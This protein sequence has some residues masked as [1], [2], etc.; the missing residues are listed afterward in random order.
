MIN[1]LRIGL[2]TCAFTLTLS[3]FSQQAKQKL[4][5]D[6]KIDALISKMTLEEKV[7]QLNINVGETIITGPTMYTSTSERFDDLIRDGKITGLFNV[8]G[9]AYTARLQKIAIEKSRLGIPLLFGADIIHGF[10]TVTPIPLGEAASWD[11]NAIEQSA[12]MAAKESTSAG[13]NFNFA[14]MVDISREPRWGRISEGSGEDSYLGSRIATARVKGFQG[15]NLAD[16]TTFAACVKHFIGYGAA[17]AGRDYNTVDFSKRALYETY[18]PPF[19]AAI[20]AGAATVMPSFNELDGQPLTGNKHLLT[21]LLRN[22][23]KFNGMIVSDYGAIGEMINH[24]TAANGKEAA[25]LSLEAGTDMDM[26]SYLYLNEVPNLVRAGKLDVKYVDAAVR[27]VLKLKFDLG[28]F[29]NPYLYSDVNREKKE[30]RSAENLAVARDMAKRSIVLLKNEGKLLP[31]KKNYKKIAVIGPLADNKED[32]N[33]SW[34]FFG[35]TQ[36]PVSIVEGIKSKVE[37]GTEVLYHTGCNLYDNNTD[38]FAE[39]V[40]TANNAD[41]V[42]MVVGESAVMN[43]EGASRSDINLPGVQQQLVEIIAK[44]GKPV[45]V[46]LINGRPLTLE[47]IDQHIPSIVESWTLGSEAGHAVADVLFGD[48]NPSGKLPVTFPRSVGQ[49]PIYYNHKN[50]GRPYGGNYSE[51]ASQRVYSSKYRDIKNTPLYPFGYGLSYTSF[52]YS[53]MNLSVPKISANEKIDVTITV[54]NTGAYDG[55]EVVQL[56]IR[57]LVGSVTRPVKELKGFQKVFLKAGESKKIIFTLSANDLSFYRADMTW[58]TE[59]GQFDVFVGG[60]S[61]QVLKKSF[62][63]TN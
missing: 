61:E 11:M 45:V 14:P 62:E 42:I 30:I 7:G 38:K 39:A 20:E 44:T 17:E 40:T 57:D 46:V 63:L 22:E 9:A 32:M 19:K 13:I 5:V 41:V 54:K 48:Y 55:E 8:H 15:N 47:W 59:R 49:I 18:L 24:G 53:D 52:E 33:G 56:Y 58:G 4:S 10:K 21:D 1:N 25:Q 23:L 50:T 35:E 36:H 29:D 16:P 3:A 34:S 43:G 37:K 12:R 28:L 6:E 26:M 2:F 31:L 27:R 51:P 60:S